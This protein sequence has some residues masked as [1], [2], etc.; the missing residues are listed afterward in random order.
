MQPACKT[1]PANHPMVTNGRLNQTRPDQPDRKGQ[2]TGQTG[3]QTGDSGQAR[4]DRVDTARQPFPPL[5]THAPAPG[6][7]PSRL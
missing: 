4:R 3:S 5:T 7:D 6:P 1:A 2:V